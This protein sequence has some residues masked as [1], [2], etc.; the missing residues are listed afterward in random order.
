M[1]FYSL[2]FEFC[3][4]PSQMYG[5]KI[6]NFDAGGLFAS[7][8]SSDITIYT[9]KTIRKAKQMYLG[10][11][12]DIPLTFPLNFATKNALTGMERSVISSWLFGRNGY[13]KLKIIQDDLNGAWFNCFLTKPEPYYVGNV[14][15]GFKTVVVCDSPFAYSP[16][17]TKTQTFTGNNVISYDFTLYNGS[18]DDD[19]LYPNITF[20]LNTVGNSFSIINLDDDDREF[21][22]TDLQ[23]S[24]I[25]TVDNDRQILSSNTD[26]LRLDNFNLNWLRL[27]PK[28]NR[29]HIESGI[30]KFTITYYES[31]KIGG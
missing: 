31:L 19:Y 10:R 16:L 23:A 13:Q 6:V 11:S 25:I 3:D 18:A 24:E 15:I 4:V 12:Q 22:F 26:L 17:I 27:L 9:Q 29:L 30:G 1:S 7:A 2:D 14:N 28:A 21:L 5:L 20:E 8:G